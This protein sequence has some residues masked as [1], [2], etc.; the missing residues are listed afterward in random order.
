MSKRLSAGVYFD[1]GVSAMM[2]K[3]KTG[4][5]M[6]KLKGHF[7]S[8]CVGVARNQGHVYVRRAQIQ[9]KRQVEVSVLLEGRLRRQCYKG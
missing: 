9:A 6:T 5:P 2:A 4:V 8:P 1:Q 3:E 7:L